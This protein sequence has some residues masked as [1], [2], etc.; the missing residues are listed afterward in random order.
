MNR[1]R[2]VLFALLAVVAVPGLSACSGG[3][4]GTVHTGSAAVVGGQ[5]I[6]VAALD[7][8]VTAFRDVAPAHGQPGTSSSPAIYGQDSSGMPDHVLQFLIKTQVV[9]AALNQKGLTVSASDVTAEEAHVLAQ[10]TSRSALE[11]QFVSQ[12]GLPP[13]DLDDWFRMTSGEVKLLQS[14]G[15][16]TDSPEAAPA[17]TKML[18][19]AAA[20]QGI[21]INPRYGGSWNPGQPQLPEA[22]QPWIKQG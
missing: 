20:A 2:T 7:S 6:S 9:Q 12:A 8:Q 19:D 10:G 14:A 21:D 1:P 22:A 17:L 11:A 5:R 18:D 3:S 13:A 16:S 4:G 15:V